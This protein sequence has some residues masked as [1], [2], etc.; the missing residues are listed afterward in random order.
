MI[1]VF[2]DFFKNCA[3][4]QYIYQSWL[5]FFENLSILIVTGFIKK[6][7]YNIFIGTVVEYIRC[8]TNSFFAQELGGFPYERFSKRN[9]FHDTKEQ[10]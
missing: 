2:H 1:Q 4:F 10:F 7:F 8:F 5:I 3:K 9:G 6:N